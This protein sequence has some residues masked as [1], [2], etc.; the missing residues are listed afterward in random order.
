[1]KSL[2]RNA[3]VFFCKELK[4]RD[5]AIEDGVVLSIADS[6]SEDGFD[7]VIDYSNKVIVPGLVD[8]H[9]HL[10]EPGFSYKETIRT[11]SEAGA[12]GGFTALCA[13]PNLNPVP[14]SVTHLQEELD[15]I[16]NTAVIPVYPY[17]SITVAQ[18]GEKLSDFAGMAKDV[19]A[20]SDD[21]VG[22]QADEMM[23]AAMQAAKKY[24]KMIVA[25]AEDDTQL[26]G[27]YIHEGTYAKTHG[28]K[29]ISSASE[30]MQV[31]RDI[32]LVRETGAAYHVCHVSTKE[33]VA[34]IRAAKEE[35]LPVTCE[36]APHYLLLDDSLLKKDGRFRMNPPIRDKEDRDALIAGIQDGTVDMI[37]TDHAPHSAEE[38]SGGLTD[39][40]NGIVGLETSFSVCY[41][42]LVQTGIIS[43]E[44]LIELMSLMPRKVFSI[45]GGLSVG[46]P[47]DITVLDLKETYTIN[48]DTF[49]SKGKSTPFA[50]W[51][52][53]GA[54]YATYVKGECVWS[55]E[56]GIKTC[57]KTIS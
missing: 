46:E 35:G 11:G 4:K 43:F 36:T 49:L 22:V 45:P 2:L 32:G 6:I 13:M 31:K 28:H 53:T 16:K 51:E 47:A 1:M 5:I 34:L 10:R 9:V 55:K 57:K 7:Y 54:P 8:V 24:G 40:L 30:W 15:I 50:G 17:G 3:A 42:G 14:D 25:H 18:K 56:E 33:S 44:R 27:G 37:A 41:D 52:V 21:G 12:R 39:S 29:G 19:I 20:F 48:P 26:S 23:R 38:K